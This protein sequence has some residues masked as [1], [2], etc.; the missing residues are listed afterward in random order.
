VPSDELAEKQKHFESHLK[1]ENC[2]SPRDSEEQKS[3]SAFFLLALS[4]AICEAF[5][6]ARKKEAIKNS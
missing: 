5:A 4:P 2:F 3:F 1:G 6:G